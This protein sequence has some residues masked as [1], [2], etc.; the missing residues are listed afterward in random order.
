MGSP[1]GP[2][3]DPACV[4][5]ARRGDGPAREALYSAL[6]KSIYTLARRMLASTSLA[7]DILHETFIEAFTKLDA[8]RADADFAAWLRRIAINKCLMHARSAWVSRRADW[9]EE[10]LPGRGGEPERAVSCA[11]LAA[12]LDAL[13][14]TARAVVWLHD[15]EGYTHKEI[16][17]L[18]GRTASFSK[19][20]LA[21]AH[22]RL[23]R[24]LADDV[25]E[26]Q[27]ELCIG[28]LK[29]C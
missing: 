25:M 17:A 4:A 26:D 21:R 3:I 14:Q 20:H 24:M 28:A 16:G 15:V 5:R 7:E 9:P 11:R 6:G 8:L 1:R 29:T 13:P 2:A 10:D 19:S 27:R 12:A 23:R 18:M 22:E